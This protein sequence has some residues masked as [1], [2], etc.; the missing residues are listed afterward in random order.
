MDIS[1]VVLAGGKSK[2]LGRNKIVEPIGNK[3]LIERVISNLSQFNNQIIVVT[4]RDSSLPDLGCYSNL[5]MVQDV[6]PDKGTLGGIYTGLMLSATD[7]NL[8]V[9]CDMPFLNIALLNHMV[10]S[11]GGYDAVVPRVNG[12]LEPLH[13]VYSKNCLASIKYLIDNNRLSVLDLYPLIKVNY[14]SEE[15]IDALDKDHLSF[16]NVNTEADL[17]S[18]R[19]LMNEK[20]TLDD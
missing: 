18:G 3:S 14:V 15:E 7:L 4:A 1:C 19:R 9:A 2:R 16:F 8:V 13:A 6:I 12:V 20:G 11:A 10:E 5:R 17:I